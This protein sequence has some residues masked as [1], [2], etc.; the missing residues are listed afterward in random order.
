[1]SFDHRDDLYVTLELTPIGNESY[2]AKLPSTLFIRAHDKI[3][4]SLCDISYITEDLSTFKNVDQPQLAI[5]IPEYTSGALIK[6][7]DKSTQRQNI[8]L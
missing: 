8:M 4:A 5:A 1:M 2:R 7:V 3:V 6:M